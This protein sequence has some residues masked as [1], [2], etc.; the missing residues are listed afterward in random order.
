MRLYCGSSL[1]KLANL[2]QVLRIE[3]AA[4]EGGQTRSGEITAV[5]NNAKEAIT[6]IFASAGTVR[7][8]NNQGIHIIAAKSQILV[9][10]NR[11]LAECRRK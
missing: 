7:D 8:M 3:V 1:A 6:R 11:V 2:Y 4:V 10:A 5:I 9:E